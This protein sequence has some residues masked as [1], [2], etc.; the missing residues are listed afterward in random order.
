LHLD[1]VAAVTEPLPIRRP[2]SLPIPALAALDAMSL[3]ALTGV[4]IRSPS[5]WKTMSG[6][7]KGAPG[8]QQVLAYFDT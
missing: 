6:T 1:A 8:R 5:P 4:T 2:A 7:S 3:S